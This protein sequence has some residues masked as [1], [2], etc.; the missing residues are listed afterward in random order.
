MPVNAQIEQLLEEPGALPQV[1]RA[2]AQLI[3]TLDNPDVEMEEIEA[4]IALDPA[5]VAKLL[6]LGNS[7]YF[8]RGRTIGS[9]ED[10][11]KMIG[12][13]KIRALALSMTINQAFP[14]IPRDKVE[15]LWSY[16]NN[17]AELARRL[18]MSIGIDEG[19]AFTSALIHAIGEL[20]M[21]VGMG[22][23]MERLDTIAAPLA[24]NRANAQDSIFGY[25]YAAV[26]AELARRWKFPWRIVNGVGN[27]VQ[28]YEND[29][30]EPLAGIIHIAAW[31]GRGIELG[32]SRK[33]LI[34]T[35]PDEVGEAL[36]LDPDL[37]L[38]YTT[39]AESDEDF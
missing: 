16:S 21:R 1:P 29:V 30:Y 12:M 37:I 6:K 33:E 20:P 24:L 13:R 9:L 7:A 19:E 34:T 3:A 10:A 2:A 36:V 17:T 18:A 22:P 31:R 27:H 25:T 14:N 28:P 38:D 4:V 39:G 11:L 5:L 26:G 32:L 35:Y 15:Q 23:A 8:W